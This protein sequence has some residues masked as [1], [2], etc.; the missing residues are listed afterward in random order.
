MEQA[1]ILRAHIQDSDATLA[2][3][4]A[5]KAEGG[6]GERAAGR[7]QGFLWDHRA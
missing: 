4:P 2:G 1:G 5:G 7:G 3:S 6:G